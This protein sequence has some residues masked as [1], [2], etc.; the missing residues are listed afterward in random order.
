MGRWT[1]QAVWVG[2][3][4]NQSGPMDEQ[5][6]MILH[7]MQGSLLGSVN[8]G[9]N[10]AS[11]VSFHFGTSKAGQCQ[12][13]VDT[14]VTAWTQAAGNGSWVSVENED[15]SGNPLNDAQLE[16]VAQLYAR[17][18]RE[19]GW[20]YQLA[21]SPGGR[22]LGWH[23]M[24]GVAWGNHPNCPGQPIINQRQAI[25]D[26]ARQINEGTPPTKG[27]DMFRVLDPDNEQFVIQF[28]AFGWAWE[29]L[30]GTRRDVMEAAGVP[31]VRDVR[32]GVFG[33]DNGYTDVRNRFIN[34]V[35]A[36]VVASLPP[37][38]GGTTGPTL[39]QIEQAVRAQL[40]ATKLNSVPGT[41]SH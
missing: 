36:K 8:W 33:N 28:T 35:A 15:F 41:F 16:N 10:P 22:G 14:D 11:Q 34:E 6:G 23:G 37:S 26:R 31:L 21:D 17:G 7:V 13:L 24:G 27:F 5:R 30:D 20:P 4:P 29:W 19:Y 39:A 40:D 18:V 3:T 12:Q 1:E 32:P 9:K 25:L 2:P 38:G